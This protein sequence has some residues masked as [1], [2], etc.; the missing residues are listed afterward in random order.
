MELPKMVTF[1]EIAT[2]DKDTGGLGTAGAKIEALIKE[3]GRPI[4]KSSALIDKYAG[5]QIPDGK[6]SLTYRLEY[7]RVAGENK[8]LECNIIFLTPKG[9]PAA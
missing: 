4:L 2:R 7:L 9:S 6:I 3:K 8:G 1:K 5:K